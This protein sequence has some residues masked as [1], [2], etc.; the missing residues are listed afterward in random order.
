VTPLL[1]I[2]VPLLLLFKSRRAAK[3]GA[4]VSACL[5]ALFLLS[6]HIPRSW[7]HAKAAKGDPVAQYKYAQWLENHSEQLGAVILRP[8]DRTCSADMHG[9]RK[10]PRRIIRLL[11][12]WWASV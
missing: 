7:L 8:S 12:G 2:G 6:F 10:P 11:C 3:R 9:L 4:V 5:L 1:L